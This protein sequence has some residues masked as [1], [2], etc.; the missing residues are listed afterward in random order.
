[1]SIVS[2]E[3]IK[4]EFVKI[5]MSDNAS[6]GLEMLRETGLLD[7]FAPELSSMWGITQNIYHIYDVWT[8]TLKALEHVPPECGLTLRLTALL[9][10]SGKPKTRSVDDSGNVHFYNHQVVSAEIAKT[11]LQRLKFSNSVVDKVAHLINMHL[12]VGEY[13]SCWSD[14][15]VRRLLRE[16][17]DD[18]QDLILFTRADKAAANPDMPSVDLEA[19]NNH[20][21]KVEAAL[22]GQRIESPLDGREI[23]EL[24]EIEP[25]PRVGLMKNFLEEQIINGTLLP[26]DKVGAA[27]LLSKKYKFI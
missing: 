17:G 27:N 6:K 23:I 14:A 4:D 24:L 2:A 22:K 18:L 13:N 3:R 15:A 1:L 11:V 12:R 8:H 26:G 21:M 9:H 7:Q 25:G 19:L 20:I 5:L 16:T 10:D